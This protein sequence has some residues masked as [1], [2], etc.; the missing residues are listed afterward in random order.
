MSQHVYT[1]LGGFRLTVIPRAPFRI[2][3]TE[4]VHDAVDV[5]YHSPR[6][7]LFARLIPH[8]GGYKSQIDQHTASLYDVLDVEPGPDLDDWRL[9]TSVFTCAW[10]RGYVLGSNNF[11]HDPSPFDLVGKNHEMISI[12]QPRN[13]PALEAMCGPN[14]TIEH[15]EKSAEGE[16]IDVEY[17]HN[18][19]EWMQRHQIVAAEDLRFVVSLQAPRPHFSMAAIAA[20]QVAQSITPYEEGE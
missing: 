14:Q 4:S 19:D 5:S 17:S 10:P 7:R 20:L 13:M 6:G 2:E 8:E 15:I 18:G 12:Q 1:R 11:P 3:R 16:W 9:K